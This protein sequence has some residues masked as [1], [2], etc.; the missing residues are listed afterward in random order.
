MLL[1]MNLG[2]SSIHMGVFDGEVLRGK[3]RLSA[4]QRTAD[5]WTALLRG[6]LSDLGEMRF[7]GAILSSV[8]PAFTASVADAARRLTG[9]APLLV[10]PG[11]KTGLEILIDNP[12]QFGSDMVCTAVAAKALYPLP[13]IVA[14]F[15]TS[16]TISAVDGKGRCL[17]CAIVPGVKTAM[18]AMTG[19]GAQL[20][21][22]SLEKPRR[23][24]GRS[25]GESIRSG[26]LYGNAA[27]LEGMLGR[28]EEELGQPCTAVA[29]GGMSPEIVPL[30]RRPLLH[31]ETLL[32]EGLRMIWEKNCG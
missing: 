5:E 15:G 20:F 24:I 25:T 18:D 22:V 8:A 9:H 12:A 11:V 21:G 26:V 6:V 13:V 1:A 27:M 17:G 3:A 28:I 10:G 23:V 30:C 2:N 29:T 31:N 16:T 4:V 14:D 19:A 32:L 7:R